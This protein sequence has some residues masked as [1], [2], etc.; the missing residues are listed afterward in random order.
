M[1][2]GNRGGFD[3]R[4]LRIALFVFLLLATGLF[5]Y[6]LGEKKGD[7]IRIFR[8]IRAY[9]QNREDR[10]NREK[11]RAIRLSSFKKLRAMI[12]IEAID[13][14]EEIIKEDPMVVEDRDEQGNTLLHS[15]AMS[16]KAKSAE[17]M[18]SKGADP[19]AL[20]DKK[21][22][23]LHYAAGQ[24]QEETVELLSSLG[25]ALNAANNNKETPLH[26]AA[27]QGKTG[28]VKI[29][30]EKGAHIDPETELG[31]TPLYYA[32]MQG[33]KETAVFLIDKGADVKKRGSKLIWTAEHNGQL[34]IIDILK[35]HGAK[36]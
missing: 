18:I 22:T 21:N 15:A 12:S 26:M 31:A 5:S 4:I 32:I 8:R 6:Y 13:K 30:L 35:K 3:K 9:L 28:T 2:M 27:A 36:E 25:A 10:V 17:F 16:G 20:N 7:K 14:M 24:G 33:H 34:E 19:R 1:V 23:P 11:G 29:L